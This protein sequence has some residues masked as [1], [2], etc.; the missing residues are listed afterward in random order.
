M[1]GGEVNSTFQGKKA[2]NSGNR[3]GVQVVLKG[4]SSVKP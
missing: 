4:K 3:S 2:D 1:E